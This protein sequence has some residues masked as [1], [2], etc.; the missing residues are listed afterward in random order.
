MCIVSLALPQDG[1]NVASVAEKKTTKIWREDLKRR[2]NLGNLGVE[3]SEG[4]RIG[5]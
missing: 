3:R 1:G 2:D 4:I 5:D